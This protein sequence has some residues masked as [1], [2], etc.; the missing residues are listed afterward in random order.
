MRAIQY[1]EYGD[2]SVLRCEQ[3]PKPRCL[4]GQV[5]IRVI[6]A[7]VNPVDS[8]LRSGEMRWV[9]PGGFPRTP[10]YDV[11]GIIEQCDP[12]G[13]FRPGD[14]AVAYLD[15]IYG[16]G[17]AEL[18]ACA[19]SVAVPL[20]TGLSWR[21]AAGLPLAGSTALQSLEKHGRLESGQ[22]V[23]VIGASGGVGSF[24]V[25][26]AKRLGAQV[27]AVAS[28]DYEGYVREL[29]ADDFIDYRRTHYA[30]EDARYDLIFDA[31]GKSSYEEAKAALNDSGRYV[32]TEPSPK[33][34]LD[35]VRTLF[36]S[37]RATPMLA[38]PKGE[39]LSRL[40][41]WAAEGELRVN[42]ASD[43]L[44]EQAADAHRFLNEQ[45][46]CGKLVLRVDPDAESGGH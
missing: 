29:G 30:D 25:P 3:R 15:N 42:I 35:A 43:F 20:P 23:L 37:Q 10:G 8:R 24:A 41:R 36:K 12:N 26:I 11:A 1:H 16:G 6:A 31:A 22:R 39:D 46:F 9:L 17:Y 18:A 32:T 14:R 28:G 21:E 5:L 19:E 34:A 27:T 38:R 13:K 7:G 4:P 45:S 44:L 40:V 2:P 33:A